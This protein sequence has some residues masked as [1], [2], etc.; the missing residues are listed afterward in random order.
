MRIPQILISFELA[1]PKKRNFPNACAL[2]HF[3][4]ADSKVISI[5]LKVSIL[6]TELFGRDHTEEIFLL[7]QTPVK[8][9]LGSI[10]RKL[11]HSGDNINLLI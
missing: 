5:K 9:P 10:F 11:Q 7:T 8:R 6:I 3:L 4:A 1:M 2:G